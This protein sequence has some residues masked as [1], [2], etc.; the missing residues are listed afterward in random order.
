MSAA[1]ILRKAASLIE[2]RAAQRDRPGGEKS[3]LAT[4]TAFNTIYGTDLTEVQGWHFMELL[5][6]VRSAYGIY[7]KDDFDDK[8]AYAALAAEAADA[9]EPTQSIELS[10]KA[11][12]LFVGSV[13]CVTCSNAVGV[14]GQCDRDCC[15]DNGWLQYS[16][17]I[18]SPKASC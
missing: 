15:P 12:A 5:K 9:H 13:P 10:A 7:V 14:L 4:I 11:K 16:P 18:A 1:D 6:M 3:M 17:K 8:V 2:E